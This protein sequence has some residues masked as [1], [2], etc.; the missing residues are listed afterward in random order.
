MNIKDLFRRRKITTGIIQ[1]DRKPYIGTELP[2]DR[3]VSVSEATIQEA[4]EYL[5]GIKR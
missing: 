5:K 1:L 4:E 3:P 2:Q